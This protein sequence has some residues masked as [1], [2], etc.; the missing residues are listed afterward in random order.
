[1][2]SIKSFEFPV[3]VAAAELERRKDVPKPNPTPSPTKNLKK[4]NKTNNKK[5]VVK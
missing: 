3:L 4:T 1:M 5:K 2:S